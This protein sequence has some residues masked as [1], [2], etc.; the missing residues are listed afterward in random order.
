MIMHLSKTQEELAN[1]IVKQI[2]ECAKTN[3]E[4]EEMLEC[5]ARLIS[6]HREHQKP[7]L[8]SGEKKEEN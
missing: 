2:I 8:F 1:D 4:V 3:R 6:W 7:E 5:I